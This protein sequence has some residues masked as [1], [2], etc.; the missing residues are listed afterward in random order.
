MA[1]DRIVESGVGAR[2]RIVYV[3][4]TMASMQMLGGLA[5]RF[6]LTLLVPASLGDRATNFWPPPEGVSI[7][8]VQ[9]PGDRVRFVLRAA[10]WLADHADSYDA[11]VALDSLVGALGANLGRR[12][13]GPPV[14]LQVGRPTLE[15]ILCQR[16]ER[17]AVR[18]WSRWL[19]AKA[20]IA[21]NERQAAAIGTVSEYVAAECAKRNRNVR[22]IA[23]QGVDMNRFAATCSKAEAR[24]RLGLPED[25]AIVMWR[26][27]LAPEKDPDT[28]LLA[29]DRLRSQGRDVHALY[30]G[31]EIAEM[32][33]RAQALG[34][35]LLSGNAATSDE[36]PLWY[37][38]ADVNV[39][40]SKSEG[41]GLSVA[42]SLA[43][44]T[45]VVVSDIGGLPEA[46]DDERRC[47]AVVPPGDVAATA[48]AIAR[49]VDDP[50][51]AA[52]AGEV[53]RKFVG[54]KYEREA[55]FDAW[56]ELIDGAARAHRVAS[57]P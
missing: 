23:W 22:A 25:G 57:V 12:R 6:D 50:A 40:T 45:P 7:D 28:F 55:S 32:N 5:E 48:E 10:R 51:L 43:C 27:R 26:S 31:G 9:L 18:T 15:Y 3:A 34:V 8:R 49:F 42:E 35:E 47:G 38:A 2:R 14:V 21:I 16:S 17:S 1:E 36:I 53:G 46:V 4:D 19:G 30:M 20:L 52:A 44:G 29:V 37:V 54:E 24:E 41:L 11:V 33:A 56:A 39:Q 13:G